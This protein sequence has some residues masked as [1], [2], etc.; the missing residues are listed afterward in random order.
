ME[1]SDLLKSQLE[2]NDAA[3]SHLYETAKWG[4][5]LAIVGFIFCGLFILLG[6]YIAVAVNSLS[7][8]RSAFSGFGP[9]IGIFYILFALIFFFPFLFLMRFSTKIKVALNTSD[10]E[11]LTEAFN[12]HRRMYKY[13]GIIAIIII[14]IY[15]LV[16]VLAIAGVV[17]R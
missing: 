6:I 15:L 1:N 4:K 3:A 12:Q 7:Y 13:I 8:Y 11:T 16:I 2:V 14:S 10:Q 17:M 9:A 5:F